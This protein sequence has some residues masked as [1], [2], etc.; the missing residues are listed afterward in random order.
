MKRITAGAAVAL[1]AFVTLLVVPAAP[2][3]AHEARTVGAYR[4][5]VGWGEEPV[6]AGTRNSVQLILTTRSGSPVNDL[7][8]SLKVDVVYGSQKEALPLELNFDPDSGEGTPGDYRGWLIP[9]AA[10]NYTFHFTGTVRGQTVD[11]S[12]T[13]GPTTFDAVQDPTT[14]EFPT[15][16]PP[17]QQVSALTQR[18]ASRISAAQAAERDAK[19]SADSA[20]TIALVGV[21]VGALGLIAGGA[22]LVVAGRRRG[23]GPR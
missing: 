23:V 16:V 5:V 13:S 22:A 6:Y 15:K 14:V 18:L 4:F 17:V 12:F 1:A 8:D 20:R 10:G 11:Q 9:T 3:L 2:A 7:G 19:H 21:I